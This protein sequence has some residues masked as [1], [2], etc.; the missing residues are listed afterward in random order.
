MS[1]TVIDEQAPRRVSGTRVAL[2]QFA[3]LSIALLVVVA[4]IGAVAFRH[5][6]SAEAVHDARAL[7]TALGR[8]AIR[9]EITPQVL[10][11]DPQALARVDASV[12]RRVLRDP[13]VRV[14]L[15]TPGGRVVYS[16][17]GSLI[18]RRYPPDEDLRAAARS[19]RPSADVSDLSRP[20][21][22]LERGRG[23][24]VEVY[25]PITL[26]DG[27]RVVL[28]TYHRAVSIDASS[29]R[30]FGQ[31][32]PV[33][34]ALLL[35][36]ALAQLPLAWFLA[37]RVRSEERERERLSRRAD[38]A[39]EAERLRIAAELHDG[40]VQDLA[41]VAYDL[42]ST[43]GKVE[44]SDHCDREVV[45]SLRR[46]STVCRDSMRALRTLLVD[47]Y[48]GERRKEGL[49]PSLEGLAQPLA[50]RGIDVSVDVELEEG[51][52]SDDAAEIVYRAAQEALRNVDRHA[53]ASTARVQL[54][55]DDGHLV[56]VV[57]DDGRGMSADDLR[58]RHAAG[59][60][61]LRLLADGVAARGGAL[62]IESE[63]GEGT[64]VRLRLP[65][66][67]RA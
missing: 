34:L 29:E 13:I 27:R 11:G 48:P 63:P 25:L 61:G 23:R 9:D 15:W 57:A 64:S 62:T 65:R 4:T 3:V 42:H 33:L 21:N 56:L 52:L 16:D 24:L 35:V 18:G 47:L 55:G 8:A 44:A 19:G 37:S 30:V 54:H 5:Y 20:E 14:K 67:S 6:A 40:V 38:D 36:L 31:F 7:T 53:A 32:T 60:M 26:S 1:T 12:R 39:R 17:A 66:A 10:A 41:G 43:A 51:Q 50:E 28:E 58:A 49:G 22:R 46:A 59:H 2:T 45:G